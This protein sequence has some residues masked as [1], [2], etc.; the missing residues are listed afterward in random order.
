MM[1]LRV[2]GF[3]LTPKVSRLTYASSFGEATAAARHAFRRLEAHS[4]ETV[5]SYGFGVG[6]LA[7]YCEPQLVPGHARHTA[8]LFDCFLIAF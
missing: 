7:T 4:A 6:M 8:P 2:A 5:L 1:A 3:A